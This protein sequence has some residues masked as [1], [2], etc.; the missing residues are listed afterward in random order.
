MWNSKITSKGKIIV[1]KRIWSNLTE[2]WWRMWQIVC[3]KHTVGGILRRY[4]QRINEEHK[5]KTKPGNELWKTEHQN[6]L[7]VATNINWVPL[8]VS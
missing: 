5:V 3:G 4:W 1:C 7:S 6:K 8:I 2:E